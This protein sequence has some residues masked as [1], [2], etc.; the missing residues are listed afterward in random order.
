MVNVRFAAS[1][2]QHLYLL[3]HLPQQIG[4]TLRAPVDIQP[5]HQFRILSGNPDGTTSS[6]AVVTVT[7]FGAERVV[8][9]DVERLVAVQG[10]ERRGA[11]ID[12]IGSQ[13]HR[14]GRIHSITNATGNNQLYLAIDPAGLYSGP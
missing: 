10:N 4:D 5:L 3:R 12:G 7:G 11:D 2:R 9:I 13:G 1:S 8:V 6:M 14:L